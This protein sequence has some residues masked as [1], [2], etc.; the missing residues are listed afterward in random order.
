M[1]KFIIAATAFSM[2]ASPAIA[3]AAPAPHK[4]PQHSASQ[5]IRQPAKPN[6]QPPRATK[7]APQPVKKAAPQRKWSKGDR[8]DH[9]Q[10]Q[11]YKVISRPKAYGL[12]DAPRGKQWVQSGRDAILIT[13]ATG[14]IASIIGNVIR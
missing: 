11:N 5:N 3:S 7:P 6:I 4:A 2:I 9:R 13:T 8:F 12:K 1:K 14:I 10:A